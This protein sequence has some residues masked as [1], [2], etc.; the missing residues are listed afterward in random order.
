VRRFVFSHIG[1]LLTWL[2][3][4]VVASLMIPAIT[5][6]WS[7]RQKEVDTKAVLIAELTESAAVAIE[8]AVTLVDV[9]EKEKLEVGEEPSTAQESAWLARY[10][11]I[12]GAW[13]VAAFTLE[14]RFAAYFPDARLEAFDRPLLAPAFHD[15]NERIQQFILLSANLCREEALR[16]EAV[17]KLEEYLSVDFL[18]RAELAGIIRAAETEWPCWRKA[19]ALREAYQELG[20]GLLGQ[21]TY[22]LDT[23]VR[24]NAAGYNVGFRDFLRQLLPFYG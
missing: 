13:R 23:I 3:A 2:G 7:D 5:T 10:H 22:F 6:Q 1:R 19:P 18:Q 15:Y 9:Q 21:R 16:L 17:E 24:S 8:D 20:E 14:S 11:A 4:L 12:L